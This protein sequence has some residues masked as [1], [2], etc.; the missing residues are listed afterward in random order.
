MKTPGEIIETAPSRWGAPRLADLLRRAV[1]GK[2]RTRAEIEQLEADWKAQEAKERA[3]HAAR[4]RVEWP[5]HLAGCGAPPFAVKALEKPLETA[6]VRAAREFLTSGKQSLVLSGFTGTGKTAAACLLFGAA[7][8]TETRTG[9][10]LREWD[11]SRGMFLDFRRLKRVSDYTAEDR[12]LL[13]RAWAV[14]VLVLDELGGQPGE[15]LGPRSLE[16][17]EELVDHRDA[18]GR[19]TAYTTNLSIQ[20][21]E[22]QPSAFA[23]FVKA[24]VLS[25]LNRSGMFRDCGTRDLRQGATP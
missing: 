13:R 14:P 22:G 2:K 24:R 7:Q 17:L 12:L 23:A 6:A 15:E 20:R 11:S 9:H 8:R 19:L 1:E 25:R 21:M 18:P 3:E 5:A 16:L 10:N 4:Q